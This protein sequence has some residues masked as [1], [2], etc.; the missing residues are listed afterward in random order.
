MEKNNFQQ[1]TFTKV[2]YLQI[3]DLKRYMSSAQDVKAW[4]HLREQAKDLWPEKIIS[5]VDGLRK[6]I[7]K[8]HKSTKTWECLGMAF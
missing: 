7:M 1:R 8:Y 4:N 2:E 6:W 3:E 5:A